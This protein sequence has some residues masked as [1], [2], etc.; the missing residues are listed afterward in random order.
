MVMGWRLDSGVG[1]HRGTGQSVMHLPWRLRIAPHTRTDW[2][3]TPLTPSDLGMQLHLQHTV[4]SKSTITFG[5][6]KVDL[7]NSTLPF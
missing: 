5:R 4:A 3:L 1:C 7:G 6:R 2:L